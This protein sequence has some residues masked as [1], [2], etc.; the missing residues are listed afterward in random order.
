MVASIGIVRATSAALASAPDGA[1][2]VRAQIE[3]HR[4]SGKPW[5]LVLDIDNTLFD[6]RQRTLVALREFYRG[7]Q[8]P[9]GQARDAFERRLGSL[10]YRD[11]DVDAR[12]TCKKLGVKD[13]V[14]V[15]RFH[16]HWVKAFWDPKQMRREPRIDAVIELA[17]LAARAGGQIFYLT[18]RVQLPY[19]QVTIQQLKTAGLPGADAQH[20]L[21]KPGRAFGPVL[22]RTPEFKASELERLRRQGLSIAAF[23]TESF[24]D[25]AA[26]ERLGGVLPTVLVDFPGQPD[27]GGIAAGT[28]VISV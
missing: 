11:L 14:F 19:M 27:G 25:I 18:G 2:F 9:R 26:A 3:R 16:A 10:T 13:Q 7:Y 8:L 1:S 20:V 6:T 28:P 5:A 24:R 12:T 22:V 15:E 17:H 21:C 23:V 4:V